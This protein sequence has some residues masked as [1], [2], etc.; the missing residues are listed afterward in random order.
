MAILSKTNCEILEHSIRS[1]D[2]VSENTTQNKG[3]GCDSEFLK[4]SCFH[5]DFT[6]R[7]KDTEHDTLIYIVEKKIFSN[8]D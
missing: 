4:F 5:F 1:A 3:A 8:I 7:N 6:E 2:N